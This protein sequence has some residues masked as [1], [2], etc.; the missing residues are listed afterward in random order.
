MKYSRE[1][2]A[3]KGTISNWEVIYDKL[4]RGATIKQ[5]PLS[6][7]SWST[8]GT[9]VRCYSKDCDLC[10]E[11]ELKCSDCPY[12]TTFYETCDAIGEPLR[13][14]YFSPN[15]ENAGAFIVKL[16]ELLV[17][18][19]EKEFKE[20][21]LSPSER[22]NYPNREDY[23]LFNLHA[24]LDDL[25]ATSLK[26][27]FYFLQ[28]VFAW[29]STAQGFSY[30]CQIATKLVGLTWEQPLYTEEEHSIIIKPTLDIKATLESQIRAVYNAGSSKV[31]KVISEEFPYLFSKYPYFGEKH[32]DK[33]ERV[34]ILFQSLN[35]G[36]VVETNTN[37]FGY[38]VGTIIIVVSE[39][40]YT[41][42]DNYTK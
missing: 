32:Y 19:Y 42:I 34:V 28:E 11:Y 17:R 9:E 25:I 40:E 22:S 12:Y 6:M 39:S 18:Y 8:T 15:K 1:I 10:K 26:S 38:K 3:I 35:K 41:K 33:E 13:S 20:G 27:P 36:I 21:F 29:D 2:N 14:F 7:L 23:S 16:K 24:N 31:K 5:S 30:W 4:S 37:R